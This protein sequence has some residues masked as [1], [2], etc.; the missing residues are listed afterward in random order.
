[1][2]LSI[3]P[4]KLLPIPAAID[5]IS[6]AEQRANRARLLRID[7][8]AE[9]DK[10]LRGSF[11]DFFVNIITGAKGLREAFS[12]LFSSFARTIA[13]RLSNRIVDEVLDPLIGKF[14]K[15]IAGALSVGSGGSSGGGFW[16]TLLNI[17]GK[18][19]GAIF[20]KS[21]AGG[22]GGGG[23]ILAGVSSSGPSADW[24]GYLGGI[25]T[26]RASGG[27]ISQSG[28]YNVGELGMERVFLPRGAYV[29]DN[30]DMRMAS[31]GG[32]PINVVV[33]VNGVQNPAQFAQSKSQIGGQVAQALAAAQA[34]R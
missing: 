18:V 19:L 16:S 7:E 14:A 23:D 11:K 10:S 33:N 22:I 34:N 5:A 31:G 29:Q 13:E 27:L 26:G 15:G 21:I 20:G 4:K 24:A 17:G 9:I 8:A 32:S 12:D 6:E 30:Y 3:T 28:F 1:M 25:G 2:S